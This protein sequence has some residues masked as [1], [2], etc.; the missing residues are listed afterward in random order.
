M[1]FH[2][3][4]YLEIVSIFEILRI[5]FIDFKF[6]INNLKQKNKLSFVLVNLKQHP[7]LHYSDIKFN[8]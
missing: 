6:K 3:F 1:N 4:S 2:I 8:H 7:V 5:L